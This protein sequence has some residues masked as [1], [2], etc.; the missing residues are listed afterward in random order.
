MA[1][2][3]Q[4]LA[5]LAARVDALEDENARLRG[6]S[7]PGA[8]PGVVSRRNLLRLGGLAA[9]AAAATVATGARA[10]H[11]STGNMQYGGANNAGS[12]A[13]SLVSSNSGETLSVENTGTGEALSVH[14][15]N[16]A[17]VSPALHAV[18]DGNGGAIVGEQ[19]DLASFSAGV[20][21]VGGDGGGV[22]GLTGGLGPGAWGLAAAG[23]GPALGGYIWDAA[24]TQPACEVSH[25]GTG[26]A[27][28]AHVENAASTARAVYERTIGTG[29]AVGGTIVNANSSA[30][31]V[32]GTT[33]G[34]GAGV[35][36]KS[37][38][39]AGGK[40][41]GKTAQVHLVPSSASTHPTSGSAGQLFVDKSYR[42]WFCKGGTNWKQLA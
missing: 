1:G 16:A 23:T 37:S 41:T 27:V 3:E 22:L 32:G 39:G 36:G 34:K 12:D 38:L 13:T 2:I 33:S 8:P 25:E 9:G 26:H 18:D 24:A 21:G 4:E 30:S 7:R 14:V 28:Y 5:E 29:P 42:L 17:S 15:S 19:T 10:A 6:E 40:F 20:T 35:E 31:A 11:A